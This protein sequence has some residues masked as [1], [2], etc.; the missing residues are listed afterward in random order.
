MQDQYSTFDESPDTA[1]VHPQHRLALKRAHQLMVAHHLA[2]AYSLMCVGQ[3][4]ALHKLRL[5]S[6][7]IV[8][9]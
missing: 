2:L 5:K 8:N 4:L 6:R 9:L 7:Q 3:L 1:R